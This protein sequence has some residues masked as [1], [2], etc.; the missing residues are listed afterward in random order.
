M[1]IPIK[2][3][4]TLLEVMISSVILTVSLLGVAGMY[5]FSARFSNEAQQHAQAVYI[6]NDIL[7]SLKIDKATWLNSVLQTESDTYKINITA[8]KT[9]PQCEHNCN[10]NEIVKNDITSWQQHLATAFAII[11]ASACLIL[12]R[13]NMTQVIH[14]NVTVNWFVNDPASQSEISTL[15][16]DCGDAGNGRR[17]FMLQTLL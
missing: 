6:T 7:E 16:N 13:Q 15:N 17:Q 3:G 5:G 1:K 14:V 11:P 9:T 12:Q 8:D 10:A 2:N 4:F